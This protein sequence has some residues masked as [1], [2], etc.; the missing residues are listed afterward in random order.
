VLT[1]VGARMQKVPLDPAHPLHRIAVVNDSDWPIH[2][3]VV[4]RKTA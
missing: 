2:S 4:A 3:W 1:Q